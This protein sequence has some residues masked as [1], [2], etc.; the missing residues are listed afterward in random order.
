[1]SWIVGAAL[2]GG[3]NGGCGAST[4][5]TGT[6]HGPCY[7]NGTCNTGLTCMSSMCLPLGDANDGVDGGTGVDS[8]SP[9]DGGAAVDAA[10][11]PSCTGT[12]SGGTLVLPS[13]SDVRSPA[14]PADEL[15]LFYADATTSH[16]FVASRTDVTQTFGTPRAL[17]ELDMVC[18]AFGGAVAPTIDVSD[19][20]LR[21]YVVCG[22]G[23]PLLVAVRASRAASAT[24]TG[25]S[26][27]AASARQIGVASSELE[28]FDIPPAGGVA[29]ATRA[30]TSAMFSGATTL[31]ELAA[32]LDPSAPSLSPDGL[33]L[34]FSVAGTGSR[35][36]VSFTR[37]S[38]TAAFDT[39]SRQRVN[40]APG[41]A[42]DF[43][44]IAPSCRAIYFVEADATGRRV[45][46][47]R[48]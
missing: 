37:T 29:R 32:E 48:R 5:A 1:M 8:G 44:E 24:F 30:T 17:T 42:V 14:V 35:E 38:A 34:Y 33:T 6:L 40:V 7:G 41:A 22:V 46:V 10:T 4:P 3:W 43:P 23:A 2:L 36:I 15:E 12:F 25:M 31:P 28:A 9:V 39:T 45:Y 47:S 16:F 21:A 20:G 27:I 13:P 19:D 18:A 11:P 26:T